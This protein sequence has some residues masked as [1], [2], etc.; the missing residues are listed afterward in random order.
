MNRSDIAFERVRKR[1][2]IFCNNKI[3]E[4]LYHRN[5]IEVIYYFM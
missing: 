2:E 5:R 3:V 4:K 1:D